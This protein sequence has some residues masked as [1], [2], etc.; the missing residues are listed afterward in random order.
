MRIE[1]F[2]LFGIVAV[3]AACSGPAEDTTA[4]GSGG[5]TATG[6]GGTG[7]DTGGGGT[8][9]TPAC[10]A[11]AANVYDNAAQSGMP[12]CDHAVQPASME[13]GTFAVT[14]FGPFATPFQLGGFS[15]AAL[16]KEGE[17]AITDPWTA[18]VVVV[19]AGEDPLEVD[20]DA[21]AEPR[22]LTFLEELP[23]SLGT[24]KRYSI[25]L[26]PP[27]SVGACDRVVVA[28]RN[29]EGPPPSAFMTCGDGSAHPETNQWWNL[30]GTM[31]EMASYPN[32]DRDW[33]VSLLPAPEK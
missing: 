25:Q 8:G 21:V 23:A 33:W 19:P 16:E 20:P 27:L 13:D 29:T 24:A 28:L 14:I 3:C 26:D 18:A 1:S 5:T 30:D 10:D 2:W 11:P 7:G 32:L 15:F 12:A 9:G 6:G 22:P 31:T 4:G 17:F